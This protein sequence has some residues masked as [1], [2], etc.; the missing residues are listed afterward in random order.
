MTRLVTCRRH[1]C[2]G[3]PCIGNSRM[4]TRSVYAIYRAGG[5]GAVSAAY[6]H[7]LRE[8]IATAVAFEEGRRHEQERT[9]LA[10]WLVKVGTKYVLRHARG[11]LWTKHQPMAS[12]WLNRKFAKDASSS[13]VG[14]RVVRLVR[15]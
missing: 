9:G 12:K 4:Q 11:F 2:G 8:D 10:R 7:L 5:F 13:I 14:S 1:R 3:T 15:R 6:P